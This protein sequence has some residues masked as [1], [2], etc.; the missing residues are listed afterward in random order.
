MEKKYMLT[1]E[2]RT[3]KG[4]ILHRIKALK[5][6]DHVK[7]GDLG[8][9]I[10]KEENLSQEGIAWIFNNAQVYGTAQVYDDAKIYD[11][12]QIYDNAHVYGDARIFGNVKIFENAQIYGEAGIFEDTEVFGNAQIFGYAWIGD[13]AQ[14]FDNAQVCEGAMIH[15]Y[16]HIYEN[17]MIYGRAKVYGKARIS[18]KSKVYEDA[19]VYGSVKVRDCAEILQY[20]HVS[21]GIVK[22]DLSKPE[23]LASS[24]KAQC[25]L[26]AINNK[27]IAY[28]LVRPDL[29]S[30]YDENFQYVIGEE[31]EVKDCDETNVPCAN[32]LHFSNPTY[33]ENAIEN[34]EYVYLEAEIDFKDIITVQQGKIR[35]RK[36][37]ILRAFKL[38]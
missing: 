35:C 9:F 7:A 6:F 33:W 3:I 27:V 18:G 4:K 22:T 28:K 21:Y 17:A 14:I 34:K 11:N 8:G 1:D 13:N 36:A 2:T 31:I 32:G 20:Q 16:A 38:D 19:H 15:D 10:E 12:V 25:N 37:K 26:L 29:T 30:F 23:N 5:D 24:I